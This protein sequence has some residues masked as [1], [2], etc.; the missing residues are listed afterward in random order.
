MIKVIAEIAKNHRI[1]KFPPNEKTLRGYEVA[2]D[3]GRS[4]NLNLVRML[5]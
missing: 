3:M 5:Y 2:E 4:L 1:G